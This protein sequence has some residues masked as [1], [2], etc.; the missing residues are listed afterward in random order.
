MNNCP[1]RARTA[2]R[3]A[4]AI[5]F[6]LLMPLLSM[7]LIGAIQV[8]TVYTH[9]LEMEG[10]ARDGALFASDGSDSTRAEIVARAQQTLGSPPNLVVTVTPDVDQPCDGREGEI[11]EVSVS[12]LETVDLLFV[13]TTTLTVEGSGA[14]QC[15]A[16]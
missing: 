7:L 10:A 4:A 12:R 16:L 9:A 11:V 8:G 2:E 1:A 6:A 13:Q 5:E 14:F 15:A 3:G